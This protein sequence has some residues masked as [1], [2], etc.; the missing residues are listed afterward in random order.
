MRVL[1][2]APPLD[3]GSGLAQYAAAYDELL[4]EQGVDVVTVNQ[5]ASGAAAPLNSL[6][7]V[8]SYVA[9]AKAAARGCDLVH[10]ELG[11]GALRE[12]YAILAL[13]RC[14]I[15]LVVTVHDPPGAVWYPFLFDVF[16][17]R[18]RLGLAM[19]LMAVPFARALD[20]WALTHVALIGTTTNAG[21]RSLQQS[22]PQVRDRIVRLD[23]PCRVAPRKLQPRN[24]AP[25]EPLKLAFHGHW[26][27]GKG[28]ETLLEAVA[29]LRTEG[30][31]VTLSLYGGTSAAAGE[32]WTSAYRA[33]VLQRIADLKL[34]DVVSIEG[35]VPDS[36][37][38]ETLGRHDAVVLPYQVVRAGH[39][40]FVVSTSAAAHDAILAGVPVV[41]STARAMTELIEHEVNGLVFDG[42]PEGLMARL[43]SLVEDAALVEG[44]RIG[45][46]RT[47]QRLRAVQAQRP[48]G[49]MYRGVLCLPKASG[50][51]VVP[52]CP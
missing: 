35:Y 30:I 42:T 10:V 9:K 48:Y 49:A 5:P 19:R 40:K 13:R 45:A 28:I 3:S 24:R 33:S 41:C 25:G 22:F 20:R 12:F 18:R 39:R 1:R 7:D 34:A 43:R 37:L 11:G 27:P 4:E 6:A 16:R 47:A 51:A 23:Y 36:E 15:P 46:V 32:R 31:A 14:G 8:R 26:M 29:G 50:V 38:L 21:V 17:R 52:D 2:L 44:L